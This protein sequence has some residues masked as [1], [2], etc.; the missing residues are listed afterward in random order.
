MSNPEPTTNNQ[1]PA[2][3]L[4]VQQ[5]SV[6]YGAVR[7]L[8][9]ASL[10]VGQG[11]IVA[12]VGPN[13]AG[14]STCMRAISGIL[15]HYD[16]RIAAGEVRFDG[17]LI[18]TLPP[19]K[20]IK[21]GLSLVPENRHV[22]PSMTVLENLHLGGYTLTTNNQ[23]LSTR[24]EMVYGFFPKLKERRK[25]R[26]GTLSTGEQQMLAMGRGLMIQPKLLLVDEPTVGLSPNF[27]DV[28]F[29][30][31]VQ[32]NKAGTSILLVEQNARMALEVS[33]RAY[34]FEVGRIALNGESRSLSEDPRIK[35]AYLGRA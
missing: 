3:L 1:Q 12:M 16:G 29:D 19:H 2:T 33:H 17:K 15:H 28:V 20:L 26:A 11:E 25:Q 9:D 35:Q 21:L 34:V 14:K 8:S 7:A 18:N 32:V 27:V 24:L 5:L 10:D 31:L 23:Q 6:E 13:G 22:F 30:T 4:Q